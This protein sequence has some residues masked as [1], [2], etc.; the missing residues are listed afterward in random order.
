MISSGDANPMRILKDYFKPS[1]KGYSNTIELPEGNNVV[2][3]RS[4]TIRKDRKTPQRYPDVPTTSGRISLRSMDSFQGLN[5]KSPSSW[6][7][8]KERFENAISKQ[9]EEINDKMAK[10]FR[11]L[12]ELTTSR[13]LEK[14]LISE[15]GKSLVIEN[16]NSISLT[17][18][19]EEESDKDDVATGDD[20]EKTNGSDAEMLVKES[21]T[22]N[23][24]ENRIKMSQSRDMRKEKEW[25]HPALSL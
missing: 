8:S 11:L 25:R 2:P 15:E 14:V 5:P 3:L 12:R 6:H 22:K 4:D 19:E 20:V 24:V 16:V 17:R 13:A 7:R 9:Q 21:E 10:I 1:H 18:G 23:G